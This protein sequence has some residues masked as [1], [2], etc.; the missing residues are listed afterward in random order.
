MKKILLVLVLF[1][2]CILGCSKNNYVIEL[3]GNPSTGYTWEYEVSEE[4]VIKLVSD[5]FVSENKNLTGAPGT[6]KYEFK[7]LKPGSVTLTFKY[8][9]SWL[10]DEIETEKVYYLMVDENNNIT[11]TKI[12][13]K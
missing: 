12:E 9:R 4:N 10:P 8:Y 7:G 1:S 5:K 2:L 3:V 11:C 6:Y 13:I